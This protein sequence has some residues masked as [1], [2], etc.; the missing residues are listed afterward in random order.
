[1]TSDTLFHFSRPQL[2]QAYE[3]AGLVQSP[4]TAATALLSAWQRKACCS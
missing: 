1:M 3:G 4:G 2:P